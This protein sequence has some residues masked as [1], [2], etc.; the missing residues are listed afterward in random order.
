MTGAELLVERQRGLGEHVEQP[1]LERRLDRGRERAPGLGGVLAA[2]RSSGSEVGLN[3][4]HMGGE[5]HA[6]DRLNGLPAWR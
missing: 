3:G 4:E 5:I 1:Q 6:A 2:E